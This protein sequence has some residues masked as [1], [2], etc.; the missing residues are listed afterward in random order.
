M[1]KKLS[2]LC[3]TLKEFA[4]SDDPDPILKLSAL[5]NWAH[6]WVKEIQSGQG[7]ERDNFPD[8]SKGEIAKTNWN[9]S[10]FSYGMEYGALLVLF[11]IL[12]SEL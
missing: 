10:M 9:D 12:E 8:D 2:K 7:L 5:K 6:E 11:K 3:W 4:L 1:I